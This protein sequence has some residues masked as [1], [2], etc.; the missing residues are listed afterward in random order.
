LCPAPFDSKNPKLKQFKEN[1]TMIKDTTATDYFAFWDARINDFA[2]SIP[3]CGKR[4]IEKVSINGTLVRF[5]QTIISM[6]ELQD[7][8]DNDELMM[9][10]LVA[11]TGELSWEAAPSWEHIVEAGE[12]TLYRVIDPSRRIPKTFKAL[13]VNARLPYATVECKSNIDTE[14]HAELEAFKADILKPDYEIYF[15]LADKSGDVMKSGVCRQSFLERLK[16]W[17]NDIGG[18]FYTEV[19]C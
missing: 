15:E 4:C 8:F 7:F 3:L 16:A 6:S 17:A 18:S 12:L 9:L 10:G 1:Y 2:G 19:V 11:D 13:P 14:T 5:G